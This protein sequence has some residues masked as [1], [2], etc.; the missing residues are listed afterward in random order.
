MG[1]GMGWDG[2]GDMWLGMELVMEW[3]WG[4][5][6]LVMGQRWGEL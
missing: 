2:S 6:G 1:L 3:A 5:L 4:G